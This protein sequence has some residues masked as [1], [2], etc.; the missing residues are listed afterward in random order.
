MT[1]F[2]MRAKGRFDSL[3]I[4]VGMIFSKLP[5]TPNQW[6][7]FGIVPAIVTAWFITQQAWLIAAAFFFITAA[8]DLIDGS[9]ARV[10]GRAT[11]FG[12]YLDTIVDRY[13]ETIVIA[14]LFFASLPTVWV[15]AYFWVFFYYFGSMMSTYVKS[16]AKEKGYVNEEIKGGI[17]ERAEKMMF[18]FV[19]IALAYFDTEYLVYM[20]IVLGIL[21]NITAIQRIVIARR[22]G[23]K[24]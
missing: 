2:A 4:R 12:A 6:T 1:L 10:T 13:T 18:L 21:A 8:I 20:L 23:K 14:S 7:L 19:G 17:V 16:A 9:V 22:L 5:F 15:S 11:L 3:S 24:N